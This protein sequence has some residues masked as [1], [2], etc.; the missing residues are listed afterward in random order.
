MSLLYIDISEFENKGY[1][2]NTLDSAKIWNKRIDSLFQSTLGAHLNSIDNRNGEAASGGTIL[3]AAQ[4][5]GEIQPGSAPNGFIF[6]YG[7]L[8]IWTSVGGNSLVYSLS[9]G[10][11]YWAD[12]SVFNNENKIMVQKSDEE[13][14]YS[15]ENIKS[16]LI[17]FSK[18]DPK[19]FISD[20]KNGIHEN[21][22]DKLD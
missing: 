17:L 14:D 11:F 5:F 18:S 21:E 15:A 10:F 13:L 7:Y 19:D 9:D 3:S 1:E 4:I 12:H 6:E 2:K 8:P 16:A 20:L 22:L